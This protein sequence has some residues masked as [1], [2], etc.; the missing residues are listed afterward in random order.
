MKQ[1]VMSLGEALQEI[2]RTVPVHV[3]PGAVSTFACT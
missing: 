1:A 2:A 3:L